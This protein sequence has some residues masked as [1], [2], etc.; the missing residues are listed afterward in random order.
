MTVANVPKV[1]VK[2]AIAASP[3]ELFDA[4]LDAESLGEWMGPCAGETRS[5]V[6]V[7]A[8]VGG[9]FEIIMH[10]PGRAVPHTGV[11]VEITRPRRLAFTW[12]SPHTGKDETLVTVDFNPVGKNTEVV[13]THERL[14]LDQLEGHTGGW[15]K[16]LDNLEHRLQPA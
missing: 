6:K 14:P 10:V 16:I 11:Y 15:T 1:V 7:D 9:A 13:V 8:R 4:W 2:R 5:D 12:N 3:Q